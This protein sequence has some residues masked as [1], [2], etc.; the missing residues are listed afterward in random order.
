MRPDYDFLPF[1]SFVGGF[2]VH[3]DAL[4]LML[5]NQLVEVSLAILLLHLVWSGL[6]GAA[7]RETLGRI[8]VGRWMLP[9]VLFHFYY[10]EYFDVLGPLSLMVGALGPV[11]SGWEALNPV[12]ILA[13]GVDFGVRIFLAS[14]LVHVLPGFGGSAKM[15]MVLVVF[16]AHLWA[17][18]H[19]T[20]LILETLI[21]YVVG[22]FALAM[23]FSA[24]TFGSIKRFLKLSYELGLRIVLYH[25]VLRFGSDALVTTVQWI[26]SQGFFAWKSALMGGGLAVVYALTIVAIPERYARELADGLFESFGNPFMVRE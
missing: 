2:I 24:W 20:K 14:T 17:A 10:L 23:G 6:Q 16:G 7:S 26:D 22:P 21:L 13:Q 4:A 8:V 11:L 3:R 15:F 9:I 5:R 18:Y 25:L 12:E 19:V 1:E